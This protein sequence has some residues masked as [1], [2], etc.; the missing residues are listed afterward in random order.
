MQREIIEIE[1][2]S[3]DEDD[4]WRHLITLDDNDAFDYLPKDTT[5]VETPPSD[6]ALPSVPVSPSSGSPYPSITDPE[7]LYLIYFEKV[8]EV[9]PD[10]CHEHIRLLYNARTRAFGEQQSAAPKDDISQGV[11]MQILDTGNYP[12]EK[13]KKN[14]LKRKR[15]S[16]SGSSEEDTE[17]TAKDRL[18][19]D[20]LH[21][22]EDMYVW[23]ESRQLMQSLIIHVHFPRLFQ[24]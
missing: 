7:I 10:I 13:H 4:A 23:S 24:P 8:L 19:P 1:D 11:I 20:N 18:M 2:D 5:D 17:W 9:F 22:G 16:G 6:A 21:Y 15:S 14:E 12:K 3:S